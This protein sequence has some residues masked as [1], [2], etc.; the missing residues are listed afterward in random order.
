MLLVKDDEMVQTFSTER[1]D[2]SFD[3][4]IRT[5][6]R[7]GRG[8]GID[9][10]PSRPLAEVTPVYRVMIVEQ[11]TSLENCSCLHSVKRKQPD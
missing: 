7:Y 1:P 4:C 3:D 9:T 5:R 6:A 11:M 10:D 8:H 2:E